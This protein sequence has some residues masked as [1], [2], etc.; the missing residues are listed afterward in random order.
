MP[1]KMLVGVW[2]VS[3]LFDPLD[4]RKNAAVLPDLGNNFGWS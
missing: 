4:L 1:V 2:F 3:D